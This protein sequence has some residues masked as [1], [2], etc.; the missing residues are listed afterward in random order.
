MNSVVD[1]LEHTMEQVSAD[2]NLLLGEGFIM[3]IF[4]PFDTTVKPL[5]HYL[6]YV[7]EEW[8][9]QPNGGSRREE[10]KVIL[11]DQLRAEV[12]YPT[13]SYI[14]ETDELACQLAKELASVVLQELRDP[15]KVTSG[16]LE[17]VK[18]KY[19]TSNVQEASR[20]KAMGLEGHNAVAGVV[21]C[22]DDAWNQKW[23]DDETR[24][25]WRWGVKQQ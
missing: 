23:S 20:E 19:C 11:M 4:S 15:H 6:D 2:G 5:E 8:T 25:C 14:R 3:N 16:Y 17:S 21:S 22:R 24:L 12:F 7:F 1:K 9:G 10:D 13:R 18:G